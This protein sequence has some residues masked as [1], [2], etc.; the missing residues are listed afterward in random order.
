MLNQLDMFAQPRT[1]EIQKPSGE[2]VTIQVP[3][4]PNQLLNQIPTYPEALADAMPK[5]VELG[6]IERT[7]F[8]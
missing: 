1:V 3:I 5:M 8:N 2:I 6:L 7:H 4:H